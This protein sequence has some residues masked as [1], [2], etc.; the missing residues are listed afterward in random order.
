MDN[1][2][3]GRRLMAM[4]TEYLQDMEA[5]HARK[6]A[7]AFYFEHTENASAAEEAAADARRIHGL[8]TRLVAGIQAASSEPDGQESE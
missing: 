4:A 8:Y 1:G 6:R 7:L 5:S 3:R 2:E